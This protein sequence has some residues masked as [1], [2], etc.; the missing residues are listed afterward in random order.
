MTRHV[1]VALFFGILFFVG[2]FWSLLSTE[3][4]SAVSAALPTCDAAKVDTKNCQSVGRTMEEALRDCHDKCKAAC[5][6]SQDVWCQ[7][8]C[9][10]RR[11]CQCETTAPAP[12]CTITDPSCIVYN[13]DGSIN[14]KKSRGWCVAAGKTPCNAVCK[15]ND[16]RRGEPEP[17]R[18]D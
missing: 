17:V 15:G 13:E 12:S 10:S 9:P 11:N 16:A 4:D 7:I 3:A 2:F 14:P 5:V 1:Y 8:I 18:R 6:T